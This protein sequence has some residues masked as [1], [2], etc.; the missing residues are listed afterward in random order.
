MAAAF[1]QPSA[2]NL[3]AFEKV[4]PG[5][6]VNMLN[7]LRYRE[8]ACYPEDHA[9][10][11]NQ[12]SGARAYQQYGAEIAGPFGRSGAKILWQSAP[13]GTVIGPDGENWDAML[14]V[15]YPNAQAFQTM[16]SDP[17]YLVGAVNRTAALADS[18]LYLTQ[19]TPQ[20]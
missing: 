3:V 1:I 6:P 14:V 12:W 17:E 10:A 4:S 19:P 5:R 8:L 9:H 16:I 20:S 15:E 7:F 2:A 11:S 18:R 13:L